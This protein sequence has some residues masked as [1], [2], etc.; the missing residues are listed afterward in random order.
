M[1]VGVASVRGVVE[2]GCKQGEVTLLP[3]AGLRTVVAPP[4][5]AMAKGTVWVGVNWTCG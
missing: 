5:N 1:M 2:E 3:T 4:D